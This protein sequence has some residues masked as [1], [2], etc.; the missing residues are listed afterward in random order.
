MRCRISEVSKS[1][2]MWLQWPALLQPAVQDEDEYE[3]D[4]RCAKLEIHL[5][6]KFEDL[7]PKL[8]AGSTEYRV[9]LTETVA[10]EWGE[11]LAEQ[12]I[13]EDSR[14][15]Q[16]R[17][18]GEEWGS[19]S[20]LKVGLTELEI[21]EECQAR[22]VALL[23][24]YMKV[25]LVTLPVT[26]R[27]DIVEPS[28]PGGEWDEAEEAARRSMDE[29]ELKFVPA[30]EAAIAGLD[31][32]EK[33]ACYC[34]ICIE[35]DEEQQLARLPCLHVFHS[36]CVETWLRVSRLCPPYVNIQIDELADTEAR[37]VPAS[38]AAIAG[39][40]K[41]EVEKGASKS[42][43][44]ICLEKDDERFSHMP[45]THVF[46]TECIERQCKLTYS[47][48]TSC[49]YDMGLFD[50]I[51]TRNVQNGIAFVDLFFDGNMSP[52]VNIQIDELADTEARMVPASE[53]AIAGLDK[54]EVE[55]GAAKSYC[56]ICLEKDDER[57]SRMPCTHVFH[58]ECIE[59]WLRIRNSCPICRYAI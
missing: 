9:G 44:A 30:S 38:E 2:A 51:L 31:K 23:M 49:T 35:E 39:L 46:H 13:A 14:M 22:M 7:A 55:K 29:E 27:I 42:Y 34:L 28:A 41:V 40:D 19:V 57:F 4:G 11:Q 56:A 58:T 48:I 53:A 8:P 10:G 17:L 26:V 1:R 20:K 18:A 12:G 50:E 24:H 25:S 6:T 47:T 52:Y 16:F 32:V 45:C 15:Y 54:I 43:C 33:E 36:E 5:W 21:P 59:R 3:E 37:M